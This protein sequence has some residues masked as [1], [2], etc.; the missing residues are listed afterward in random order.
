MVSLG[1]LFA[2]I[3]DIVYYVHNKR[4]R[5]GRHQTKDG[6]PPYIYTL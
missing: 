1:M 4:V 6:S 2:I 5:D 3:Q